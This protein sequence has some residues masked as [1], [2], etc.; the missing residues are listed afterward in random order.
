VT[1]DRL[2]SEGNDLWLTKV[3]RP[4]TPAGIGAAQAPRAAGL[5]GEQA[6]KQVMW[7]PSKISR[8]EHASSRVKADDLMSCWTSMTRL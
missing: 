8:L 7:Q 2:E 6:A 5:T 3:Q 4:A 1:L